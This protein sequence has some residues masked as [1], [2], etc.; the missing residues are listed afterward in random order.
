MF[1]VSYKLTDFFFDKKEVQDRLSVAERKAMSKIGTYIR[2]AA[3]SSIR[4]R[5]AASDPGSPPS[6]H[7]SDKVASIRNILFA[8]SPAEHSVIVGPVKLNQ[9]TMDWI[10]WSRTTVPKLLEFGGVQTIFEE[11]W[12]STAT[13]EYNWWRR[14]FR[15][16]ISDRKEYRS[17]RAVYQP[18][19]F[20][21]PALE[22]ERKSAKLIQAWR[23]LL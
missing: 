17:R 9:V 15:R 18:R 10:A 2:R 12:K 14:D 8:Y 1:D 23:E 19:P 3:R 20:M 21:G 13:K 16:K 6:A 22:Q 4:K 7:S 5:K 11:R